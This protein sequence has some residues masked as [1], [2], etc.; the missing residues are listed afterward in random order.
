[1]RTAARGVAAL[2]F[3]PPAAA[4]AEAFSHPAIMDASKAKRELSWRPHYSSLEALRATLN[5]R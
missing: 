2:P 3:V 5:S 4:W 1:V